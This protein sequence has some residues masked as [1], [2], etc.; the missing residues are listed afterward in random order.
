[1]VTLPNELI[2]AGMIDG[3]GE[4]RCFVHIVLPVCRPVLG[5]AVALSFAEC[6]NL[7]EQ[8]LIY[9]SNNPEWQPLS[10]MF[11]EIGIS[12]QEIAFAGAALYILPALFVYMFFQEDIVLGIQLSELK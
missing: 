3:A 12:G 11:Q 2:E 10:V 8:P 9:L 6:W 4:I 5:A 7:V 1:M